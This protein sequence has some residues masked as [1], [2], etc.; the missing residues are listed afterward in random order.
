MVRINL[1]LFAIKL[2]DELAGGKA[3]TTTV[4]GVD[5]KTTD[6]MNSSFSASNNANNAQTA[7]NN[8]LGK[9]KAASASSNIVDQSTWDTI[10]SSFNLTPTT[11]NAWD[12]TNGL[13][14]KLSTGRTSYTDQIKDLM[15]KI[16]NRDP[17]EYDADS[18]M[19][20]QQYLAS[21]MAS[22]KTAMQ[23]TMGQA[24]ALTG[25]YGSTFYLDNL[26]VSFNY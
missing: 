2:Q 14:Q 20:F 8:Q 9:V 15:G 22:G 21:S 6:T 1:Q 11:Q 10:N 16:Q 24:A 4:N 5:K 18:D 13:L 25:G 12:Y 3:K 19:L 26:D 7:A 23:D 17:F